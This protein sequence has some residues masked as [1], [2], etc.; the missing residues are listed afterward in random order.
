MDAEKAAVISP[1]VSEGQ[2]LSFSIWHSS[3]PLGSSPWLSASPGRLRSWP[4]SR[5]SSSP[6]R[7]HGG[8]LRGGLTRV[9]TD[10]VLFC[11]ASCN[12]SLGIGPG[13][14]AERGEPA[15]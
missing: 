6:F 1:K 9:L 5:R 14:P 4:S 12:R 2:P 10:G 3:Y 7:A 8:H 11:A 13:P 15:T